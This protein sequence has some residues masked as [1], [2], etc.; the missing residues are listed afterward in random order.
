M[1]YA[2]P[3]NILPFRQYFAIII[4]GE[5]MKKWKS[6]FKYILTCVFKVLIS[7]STSGYIIVVFLIKEKIKL[8][9]IPSQ[10]EFLSY[11]IYLLVPAFIIVICIFISRFLP[12]SAI[13]CG[14]KEVELAD[15]SFLPNYLGYFFVALSVADAATLVYVYGIIF[16]FTFLSQTSY[17]N[18]L[19]LLFRFHFY[20]VTAND[21]IKIYLL[22]RKNMKNVDDLDFDNINCINDFIF[23]DAR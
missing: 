7:A 22:T 20:L 1:F 4:A 16:L 18:P 11:V 8:S 14:V 19:F 10:Y 9:F 12:D 23:I 13:E 5:D 21:G 3:S 17:F 15:N 6:L 2:I